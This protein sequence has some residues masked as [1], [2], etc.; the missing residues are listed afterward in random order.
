[1][2]KVKYYKYLFI[3]GA[4][5]NLILGFLF[6]VMPV[7]GDTVYEM[8][9]VEVP[10]SLVFYHAFFGVVFSFGIGYFLVARDLNKNHGIV[11]LGAIAK[12]FVFVLFL[13]YF[14]IGD[15]NIIPVIFV[16]GDLIFAILFAEFLINFK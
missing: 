11:F 4:L 6:F 12:V 8:T 15:S 14:F 7:M 2:D 10:P 9:G 16:I 1:M 13:T 5:W 3:V